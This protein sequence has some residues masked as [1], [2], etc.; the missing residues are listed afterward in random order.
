M[1]QLRREK[2]MTKQE[3]QKRIVTALDAAG[4]FLGCST[5]KQNWF[6][7]GLMADDFLA[8]SERDIE[9]YVR[10]NVGPYICRQ[11]R[12]TVK[13]ASRLIDSYKG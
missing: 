11:A 6:L 13:E 2:E 8:Q 5:G 4:G 12:L 9:A 3:V 1:P 7:A 10:W